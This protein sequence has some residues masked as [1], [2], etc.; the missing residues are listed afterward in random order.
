VTYGLIADVPGFSYNENSENL[1]KMSI[2]PLIERLLQDDAFWGEARQRCL[3]KA[4]LFSISHTASGFA[5]VAAQ[6]TPIRS[7][8][9]LHHWIALSL[10]VFWSAAKHVLG[11]KRFAARRN[12][13]YAR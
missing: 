5:D 6:S 3:A 7:A 4:Q 2:A 13:S 12:Q 8:I 11:D 10:S 1:P 9:R